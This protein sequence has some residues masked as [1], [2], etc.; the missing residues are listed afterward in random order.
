MSFL[1]QNTGFSRVIDNNIT[2][3]S[4]PGALKKNKIVSLKQVRGVNTVTTNSVSADLFDFEGTIVKLPANAIIQNVEFT[5]EAHLTFRENSKIRL[6]LGLSMGDFDVPV[7]ED[8]IFLA[9]NLVSP[10]LRLT[11]NSAGS[12]FTYVTVVLTGPSMG[13]NAVSSAP[14][15]VQFTITYIEQQ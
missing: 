7:T 9:G 13:V 6:E 12:E 11:P 1:S 5:C 15:N 2:V 3:S 14:G 8:G 10:E 4:L